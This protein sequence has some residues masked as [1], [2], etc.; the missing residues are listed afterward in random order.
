[1]DKKNFHS[2]LLE[3]QQRLQSEID[4]LTVTLN[5]I[6]VL[7][8]RYS[9]ST[10]LPVKDEEGVSF[11]NKVKQEHPTRGGNTFTNKVLEALEI[12]GRGTAVQV[13]K[14]ITERYP[15]ID[16]KKAQTDA[17]LSLSRLNGKGRVLGKKMNGKNT[18]LYEFI[19]K[20]EAA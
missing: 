6:N 20:V 16:F 1:M 12:L 2:G 18:F 9:A 10:A 14:T 3:E 17:R 7:L 8:K 19:K 13:G 15:E 11:E 5:A 4:E